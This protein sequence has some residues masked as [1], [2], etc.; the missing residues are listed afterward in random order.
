M[1]PITVVVLGAVI[2]LGA[3]LD[4]SGLAAPYTWTGADLTPV[5]GLWQVAAPAVY[6]PLLLAGAGALAWVVARGRARGVR[7]C[8]CGAGWCGRRWRPS[9]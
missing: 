5:A 3:V 8:S 7:R 4:P 9:W 6:V 1:S 2:V